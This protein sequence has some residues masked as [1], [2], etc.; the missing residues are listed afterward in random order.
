MAVNKTWI[1]RNTL[2]FTLCMFSGACARDA[3]TNSAQPT[4]PFEHPAATEAYK[5]FG[6]LNVESKDDYQKLAPRDRYLYNVVRFEVDV[7]N[8]GIDQY[9]CNPAGEQALDCLEAL[10][11]IGANQA[12]ALLRS[13]CDL[14]PEGTPA[15][16]SEQRWAQVRG[17]AGQRHID[18]LIGKRD[19]EVDLY[20]LLMDYYRKAGKAEE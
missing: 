7:M 16:D 3:M 15:A 11:A 10:R 19:V 18:E 14:L 20:Q 2:R 5:V 4:F 9:L 8:G 6:A 1:I 12:F 13:A 17:V